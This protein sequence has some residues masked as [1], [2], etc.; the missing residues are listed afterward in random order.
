MRFLLQQGLMALYMNTNTTIVHG[1]KCMDGS[2]NHNIIEAIRTPSNQDNRNRDEP[3]P[4]QFVGISHACA[5]VGT[6][7]TPTIVR[8]HIIR[9]PNCTKHHHPEFLPKQQP[10]VY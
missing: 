9:R 1:R 8:E 10:C 4:M 3:N 2:Q 5:I 6:C 7:T